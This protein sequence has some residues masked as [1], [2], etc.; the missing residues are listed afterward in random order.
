MAAAGVGFLDVLGAVSGVLGIVGF[1]LTNIPKLMDEA[2]GPTLRVRA[3]L[4]QDAAQTMGGGLDGVYSFDY[5]NHFIGS[6]Y[7]ED[8]PQGG[9]ND[10][11]IDSPDS[12]TTSATY[13]QVTNGN[14]A[15][16]IAYLALT[17][18]DGTSR[19][20]MGDIGWFCGAN[21]YES[22]TEAG[23]Y[24]D[25]S[26]YYPKCT[27]LDGDATNG[28]NAVSMK[29]NFE[30]YDVTGDTI[31]GNS[32]TDYCS[33]TIFSQS[34]D[35]MYNDLPAK[36]KR[37][38]HSN[39]LR[40]APMTPQARKRS[41]AMREKLVVSSISAHSAKKMCASSTSY[42]PDF[43]SEA[44]GVYCD[45]DTHTSYPLCSS[46]ITTGCF[47]LANDELIATKKYAIRGRVTA[48]KK[49]KTID[50]W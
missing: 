50:H 47:D 38:L 20:W 48:A 49:H 15:T 35:I 37:G 24:K 1:G 43:V 42:G 3:G 18:A 14:D 25:G 34:S 17:N 4:P 26:P 41:Q 16:C 6:A 19:T 5:W 11:T 22:A 29:I 7:D 28:I 27:W 9:F 40:S 33:G 36:S 10:I 2:S 8:I 39:S 12:P 23:Q 46:T 30:T 32:T 13:V 31:D 45:M 21:W 44:E